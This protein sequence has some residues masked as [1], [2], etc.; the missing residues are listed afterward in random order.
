MTTTSRRTDVRAPL[1]FAA[2]AAV[3]FFILRQRVITGD[4][5]A[6]ALTIDS[7]HL[8]ERSI[9][10]GYYVALFALERLLAP[11]GISLDRLMVLANIAFMSAALVVCWIWFEERGASRIEAGLATLILFLTGNVLFQGSHAEMYA[12][13]FLLLAGSWLAFDRERPILAGVLFAGA[14]WVSPI[15][16]V[17]CGPILH[18]GV[19]AGHR[20]ELAITIAVALVLFGGGLAFIWREYMF[21][22][23]GLISAGEEQ[24]FGPRIILHNVLWVIKNFHWMGL[25]VPIGLWASQRRRDDLSSLAALTLA[26]HLPLFLGMRADGVFILPAYPVIAWVAS[27]GMLTT[28]DA[29]R[30]AARFAAAAAVA[31]ACIA[32]TWFLFIEP[33]PP[34][35]RQHVNAFLRDVPSDAAVVAEWNFAQALRYYHRANGIEKPLPKIVEAEFLSSRRLREALQNH[36]SVYVIEQ[37]YPPRDL[38]LL[39]QLPSAARLYEARTLVGKVQRLVP[40]AALTPVPP[41]QDQP[42]IYQLHPVAPSAI[43]G[44]LPGHDG[45]STK[46]GRRA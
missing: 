11:L 20:R 3:V 13:Q 4:A 18:R 10:I 27:L 42:A 38:R 16:A 41:Y 32:T 22:T 33:D 12:L 9:H 25:F 31:V 36:P 28:A 6:Y 7:G 34:T 29:L 2:F 8:V 35:M 43:H 19:R 24:G 15:A 37:F 1:L 17:S 5:A 39:M 23:R 30:P 44:E 26:L 46:T 45:P 40:G 21:G 14:M